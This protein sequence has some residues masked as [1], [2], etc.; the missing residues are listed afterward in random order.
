MKG[1]P[2][3]L[4]IFYNYAS[5]CSVHQHRNLQNF[6][7]EITELVTV[8]RADGF[9]L[10]DELAFVN[11]RELYELC[12]A[13]RAFGLEFHWGASSESARPILRCFVPLI[14]VAAAGL[15]TGLRAAMKKGLK[16]YARISRT[17][18]R[19]PPLSPAMK[20]D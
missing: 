9:C 16:R 4:Y 11:A 12:D 17:I 18:R 3:N 15:Y 10:V 6:M 2:V 19:N 13:I 5:H 14:T 1:G 7:E 8:Y 20:S